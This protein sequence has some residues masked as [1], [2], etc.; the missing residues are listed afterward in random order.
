MFGTIL[1]W[2]NDSTLILQTV[3][4]INECTSGSVC[5]TNATCT[6]TFGSFDC[7]CNKGLTGDGINKC[8]GKSSF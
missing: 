2:K 6:N 5:H 4:D 8:D 3:T 1:S 7:S